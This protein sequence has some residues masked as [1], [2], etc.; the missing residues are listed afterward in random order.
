MNLKHPW[1]VGTLSVLLLVGLGCVLAFY[2]P[3]T[4]LICSSPDNSLACFRGAVLDHV[5]QV[6]P[7]EENKPADI[8]LNLQVYKSAAKLAKD[9]VRTIQKV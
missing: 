2:V 1:L 5:Q 9:N 4:C 8:E 7:K 6:N 3:A